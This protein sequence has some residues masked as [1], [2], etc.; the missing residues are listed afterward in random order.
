MAMPKRLSGARELISMLD[1]SIQGIP[2]L[3]KIQ[4]ADGTESVMGKIPYGNTLDITFLGDLS[5]L[6]YGGPTIFRVMPLQTKY[7][8]LDNG[9]DTNWRL[10]FQLHVSGIRNSGVDKDINFERANGLDYS[11]L[12]DESLELFPIDFIEDIGH[13]I[14]QLAKG[15]GNT[16]PFIMRDTYMVTTK[17]SQA[18]SVLSMCRAATAVAK[19]SDSGGETE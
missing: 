12:T 3:K 19:P 6:P 9:E 10:V 14:V 7:M 15:D 1:P 18:A 13:M 2:S 5:G 4:N 8:Y 16:I 11:I 17:R